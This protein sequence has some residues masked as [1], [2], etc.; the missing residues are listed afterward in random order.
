MRSRSF[1]RSR[2]L[3]ATT[4]TNA[5]RVIAA[6]AS[7]PRKCQNAHAPIAKVAAAITRRRR[8]FMCGD[9]TRLRFYAT[10]IE[11]RTRLKRRGQP[12][13]MEFVPVC[14]EESISQRRPISEGATG[15]DRDTSYHGADVE[16][17]RNC[18]NYPQLLQPCP[19]LDEFSNGDFSSVFINV[20]DKYDAVG[21]CSLCGPE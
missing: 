4:A 18:R 6:N 19:S 21:N 5:T 14:C 9:L 7:S 1:R 11:L 13:A 2:W 15:G 3:S 16:G 17:C 20:G 8:S 10:A 12:W